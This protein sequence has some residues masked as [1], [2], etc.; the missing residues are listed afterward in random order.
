MQGTLKQVKE[1]HYKNKQD[2]NKKKDKN[3]DAQKEFKYRLK[4][5]S[6]ILDIKSEMHVFNIQ[7][8]F[9]NL[10]NKNENEIKL[11]ERSVQ[12]EQEKLFSYKKFRSYLCSSKI[13]NL[14]EEILDIRKLIILSKKIRGDSLN[15]K[16]KNNLASKYLTLRDKSNPMENKAL[17]LFMSNNIDNKLDLF[18]NK[19]SKEKK[20]ISKL[21]KIYTTVD[22]SSY[23][24]NVISVLNS[25][26]FGN[27]LF[28]YLTFDKPYYL[29]SDNCISLD[30]IDNILYPKLSK[31]NI[32]NTNNVKVNNI[33]SVNTIY[34]DV[35][36]NIVRSCAFNI[37]SSVE[38]NF[39]EILPTDSD[40]LI[41]FNKQ[42]NK[43]LKAF[44][45][46]NL[47]EMYSIQLA[48]TKI[49]PGY[50]AFVQESNKKTR[51]E[52]L[53]CYVNS[54]Y[55]TRN[56]RIRTNNIIENLEFFTAKF[57]N[58]YSKL[59]CSNIKSENVKGNTLK[60][61]TKGFTINN[62]INSTVKGISKRK[63]SEDSRDLSH[64]SKKD[65]ENTDRK[66]QTKLFG[67]NSKN[68]NNDYSTIA[69]KTE[70]NYLKFNY[71][72]LNK[73][74]LAN[75]N[76]Y[77]T[78]FSFTNNYLYESEQKVLLEEQLWNQ[79]YD[80]ISLHCDP[81]T[82]LY[83]L[84][85]VIKVCIDNY[86]QILSIDKRD[87][88]YMKGKSIQNA[89]DSRFNNDHRYR[90]NTPTKMRN[91]NLMNSGATIY[92]QNLINFQL[93]SS[94]LMDDLEAALYYEYI[95]IYNIPFNSD[96]EIKAFNDLLLF[97]SE[98]SIA[99]SEITELKKE[100]NALL[101]KEKEYISSITKNNKMSTTPNNY[102]PADPFLNTKFNIKEKSISFK[103]NTNATGEKSK[104]T[105][106]QNNQTNQLQRS[107]TVMNSDYPN[108]MNSNDKNKFVFMQG[109]QNPHSNLNT[110]NDEDIIKKDNN[111]DHSFDKSFYKEQE[112]MIS[113]LQMK[114]KTGNNDSNPFRDKNQFTSSNK[115]D[116]LNFTNSLDNI[117]QEWG[118]NNNYPH[119][120]EKKPTETKTNL[121]LN[122]TIHT[123][124]NTQ[125]ILNEEKEK[126]EKKISDIR[127][128]ILY[129]E[130]II[131]AY[132]ELSQVIKICVCDR[133]TLN[134]N[135]SKKTLNRENRE[136]DEVLK[137]EKSEKENDYG[138]SPYLF[139]VNKQEKLKIVKQKKLKDKNF[140]TVFVN[141][142]LAD[143]FFF[144]IKKSDL[145]SG[146]INKDLLYELTENEI[147][148][149]DKNYFFIMILNNSFNII[150]QTLLNKPDGSFSN[151]INS[152]PALKNYN[153]FLIKIHEDN[154]DYFEEF[155][156]TY[157]ILVKSLFFFN[158]T[159]LVRDS[160]DG[161]K[162]ASNPNN[163]A[164]R[165]S[166]NFKGS[167]NIAVNGE[168]ISSDNVSDEKS[169]FT[170]KNV[171]GQRFSL[172]TKNSGSNKEKEN[173]ND[174]Y[175]KQITLKTQS[176][177]NVNHYSFNE[178]VFS[179]SH[180]TR[181]QDY[182]FNLD[183]NSFGIDTKGHYILETKTKSSNKK[184]NFIES[185][186]NT[187]LVVSKKP[188]NKETNFKTKVPIPFNNVNNPLLEDVDSS[189]SNFY[190]ISDKTATKNTFN[191]SLSLNNQSQQGGIR[192]SILNVKK[193]SEMPSNVI[194]EE[195]IMKNVKITNDTIF[196][197]FQM[198]KYVLELLGDKFEMI[199]Y[200]GDPRFYYEIPIKSAKVKKNE[201]RDFSNNDL[202]LN[203]RGIIQLEINM[204][205]YN[206]LKEEKSETLHPP[207]NMELIFK[208]KDHYQKFYNFVSRKL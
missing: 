183:Q 61:N 60:N 198:D 158:E 132:N 59:L 185:N 11:D 69:N 107:S 72:N 169:V 195:N 50:A 13:D 160:V 3:K 85:H 194:E 123:N 48:K 187:P 92:N 34:N 97:S 139:I 154:L 208:D 153:F 64:L 31:D 62:L 149:F 38:N 93:N 84:N 5:K 188:S 122:N 119:F 174:G 110:E 180:K 186:T 128:K 182:T 125:N 148:N 57:D 35:E 67:I 41:N 81:L 12:K 18:T 33:N 55:S 167:N 133:K 190:D 77:R 95:Q 23:A 22:S 136:D 9:N 88:T 142:E 196:T 89:S 171:G 203:F 161:D 52:K 135:I 138:V 40:C 63:N 164:K 45:M 206:Q 47:F 103:R 82:L 179:P 163:Q 166:K 16:S 204:N 10:L 80:H 172:N 150:N 94:V 127:E 66:I 101:D 56:S 200:T 76:N 70:F 111:L 117:D 102:T 152:N 14:Q 73:L 17:K 155:I 173:N 79:L 65:K 191:N 106:V 181:Q 37:S 126:R 7:E 78:H 15:N 29:K 184:V 201:I 87:Q 25:K 91:V 42:R 51:N 83:N 113:E 114:S 157:N 26:G 6:F 137:T 118:N 74:Y 197:I 177:N 193:A 98:V 99:Y 151:K 43:L 116:F 156:M 121:D 39:Q 36:D 20:R 170:V 71:H 147:E 4:L 120:G 145:L 96:S 100:L 30:N 178:A 141:G 176:L 49:L 46:E 19:E 108:N 27:D 53:Y 175:I 199:P 144:P 134:S 159:K 8:Y 28:P 105:K 202:Y 192:S 162:L 90:M 207:N 143:C 21:E 130:N 129:Y 112:D 58:K 189:E 115:Y 165:G 140:G 146:A 86:T 2:L 32:Y 168:T 109:S 1:E 124:I 54:I 131:S 68:S 75:N 44:T 24:N 205:M 104:T